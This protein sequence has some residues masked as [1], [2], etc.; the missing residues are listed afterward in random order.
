MAFSPKIAPLER[1]CPE[2][3][4][5]APEP[6]QSAGSERIR[7]FLFAGGCQHVRQ[8]DLT[9]SLSKDEVE[10]VEA[11]SAT[12][13]WFDKLT[14][15][16]TGRALFGSLAID[17]AAGAFDPGDDLVEAFATEQVG[18]DVGPA[19]AYLLCVA[20]HHIEAGADI[21]GQVGMG[22]DE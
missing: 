12:T 10:R 15:R 4:L 19:F 3:R 11:F 13:S 6:G 1:F 9:L 5:E 22:D 20:F 8:R 21:G 7:R 17:E 16:P 2:G 18:K 14:M